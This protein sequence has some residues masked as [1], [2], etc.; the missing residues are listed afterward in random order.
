ME[1]QIPEG[2]I[3]LRFYSR[4]SFLSKLSSTS[5]AALK[6]NWSDE[7]DNTILNVFNKGRSSILKEICFALPFIS[8]SLKTF[9]EFDRHFLGCI[10]AFLHNFLNWWTSFI[11]SSSIHHTAHTIVHVCA[12]KNS[13][14][15]KWELFLIFF[16]ILLRYVL[17]FKSFRVQ[18]KNQLLKFMTTWFL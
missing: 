18:T 10:P 14:C 3:V 11:A 1:L 9:F 16:C 2:Q 5:E 13:F 17:N 8:V 12:L 4:T 15:S 7:A 6:E